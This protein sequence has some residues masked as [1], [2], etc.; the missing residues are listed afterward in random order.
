M[1]RE[2][3][4]CGNCLAVMFVL[5]HDATPTPTHRRRRGGWWQWWSCAC[6]RRTGTSSA[7]SRAPPCGKLRRPTHQSNLDLDDRPMPLT[8]RTHISRTPQLRLEL[9]AVPVQPGGAARLPG[10]GAGA[11]AGEARG[12]RGGGG[13]GREGHLP[14]PRRGGP[15]RRHSVVMVVVVVMVPCVTRLGV[16]VDSTPYHHLSH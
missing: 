13:V 1:R 10:P 8:N 11:G 14:P 9:P 3:G 16:G 12:A 2:G 7:V 5:T 4:A 6:A 15:S